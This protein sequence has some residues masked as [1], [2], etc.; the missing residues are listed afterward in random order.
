MNQ[1]VAVV[2]QGVV[3]DPVTRGFAVILRDDLNSKWLPIYVGPFEAQ[4]IALEMENTKLPRPGTHDLIKIILDNLHA[5]VIK[6]N[7]NDLKDNTFYASITVEANGEQ[8]EIDSR[9]SDAIAVALR[10]KAPILV[11]EKVIDQAGMDAHPH[12]NMDEKT[13][14]L[15]SLQVKL[16]EAIEKENYEDAAKLRDEITQINPDASRKTKPAE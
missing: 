5:N 10:S 1:M 7:I 3:V 16:N 14:K 4:S 13:K 9:P 12:H 6:V 11:S 8:K 15:N 2:V